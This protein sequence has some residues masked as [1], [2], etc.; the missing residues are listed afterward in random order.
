MLRR[1]V[2]AK[3]AQYSGFDE[4]EVITRVEMFGGV[5]RWV[6]GQARTQDVVIPESSGERARFK[7]AAEDALTRAIQKVSLEDLQHMFSTASYLDLRQQD[8]TGILVPVVPNPKPGPD[9][10]SHQVPIRVQVRP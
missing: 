6:L 7:N 4:A 9:K 2:F 8:V 5:P 3:S 10:N 1:E